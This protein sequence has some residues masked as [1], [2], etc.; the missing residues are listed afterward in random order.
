MALK[1]LMLRKSLTDAKKELETL[2]AGDDFERREAELSESIEEAKTEEEKTAVESAIDEFETEKKEYGEKVTAL[3]RRISEIEQEIANEEREQ[4]TDPEKDKAPE[5]GRRDENMERSRS[6]MTIREAV[7]DEAVK[8]FLEETRAAMKEK[9]AITNVGLIVPDVML[10]LLR[11]NIL[12]Y[13]KLY[14]HVNV[15]RVNGN[16]RQVIMGTVP[17]A[18][19]TDCCANLNELSLAFHDLELDCWKVGGYYAICNADLEDSD[20]DLASAILTAL[21][22]AIGL[23]LDKAI[24]A[25]T[26]TRMP[27]GVLTRLNQTTEPAGYSETARP[28]ADLSASN[29]FSIASTVTGE[30]LF[31]QITLDSGAAKGIYSRGEK[32]WCMNETTYTAI[33]AAAMSVDAGGAIVSGVNGAMPVIG[34]V[35]EVLNFLP[36]YVIIGGYF[37]LYTLGERAGQQ[38]AT[39]EHVQFIQDRTVMKGTARYDGAPAIAEAFIAIGLNGTTPTASAITFAPDTANTSGEG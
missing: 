22:Q 12:R 21:G 20:I 13:S 32:V 17:E 35:I 4:N 1:V 3:E 11:E 39:S 28:W 2:Q 15:V 33:I 29:V 36:D 31:K 34:G 9:R 23:A 14:R 16:G 8:A 25:G 27:L 7:H 30:D 24:I 26:G 37:D 5:Q 6:G 10:G 18:V 38:F 19:W